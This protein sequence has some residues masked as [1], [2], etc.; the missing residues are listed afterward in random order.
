VEIMSLDKKIRE[1]LW[2]YEDNL[3]LQE[4]VDEAAEKIKQAFAVE[5]HRKWKREG[6]FM[7]GTEWL[8]RFEKELQS[9]V[10]GAYSGNVIEVMYAAR[11]ASG[12][13]ES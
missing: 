1:I 5:E 6:E 12:L 9:W 11:R 7:T 10:D 8:D 2:S 3:H 4:L 13:K